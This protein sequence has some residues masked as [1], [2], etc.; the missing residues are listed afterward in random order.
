MENRSDKKS[1]YSFVDRLRKNLLGGRLDYPLLLSDAVGQIGY[2][3]V[4]RTKMHTTGLYGI[5]F[6]GDRVNTVILNESRTR[7][8]QNFDLAH[9]L[10]HVY[11]HRWID[12][13]EC[14]SNNKHT[15]LEWEA[16]EGA[17]ELL[18]PYRLFLSSVHDALSE[19]SRPVDA[20][21]L[22]RLRVY[23]AQR[24]HVSPPVIK[25]RF[26]SLKYEIYDALREA[27]AYDLAIATNTK[28]LRDLKLEVPSLNDIE[29]L[30]AKNLIKPQK[31]LVDMMDGQSRLII[32]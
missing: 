4:K 17:A 7:V 29:S 3:S 8:E 23:L 16:N 28:H 6:L 5:A 12:H 18:V 10:I 9:E 13:F 14:S 22:S 31:K 2:L 1:L 26:E 19:L 30:L 11:K 25:Y 20:Y 21:V 32:V 27:P 24:F 15:F